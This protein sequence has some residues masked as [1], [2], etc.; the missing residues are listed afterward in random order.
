MLICI[1]GTHWKTTGALLEAHWLPTI[2]SPVA[3]QCTLGSKFQTHWIATGRPLA[4]GKGVCI[5]PLQ[6]KYM[7]H[8]VMYVTLFSFKKCGTE[9]R[10]TT[11]K[12]HTH[13]DGM[14]LT[15]LLHYWPFGR[16]IYWSS[17]DPRHT[18]PAMQSPHDVNSLRI[19]AYTQWVSPPTNAT[20]LWKHLK[21]KW[22]MF[23]STH[24]YSHPVKKVEFWY[25]Y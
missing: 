21:A 7:L 23:V 10:Q 8:L 17:L 20:Q 15:Q 19:P 16:I 5:W 18:G 6:H 4:Q 1:I 9:P 12:S 2:L 13:V 3:F 24:C 25:L 11:D 14:T 22:I